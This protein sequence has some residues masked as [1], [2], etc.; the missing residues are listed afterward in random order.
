MTTKLD[1]HPPARE[2]TRLLGG[3]SDDRLDDP[4]PCKGTSVAALLDHLMGLTVA[5]RDAATKSNGP[6]SGQASAVA[7][8]LHPDWR[9]LLPQ[10]LDELAA[11][12]DDPA[13]W[14]GITWAGGVEMPAEVIASVAVDELVLHGWDLAKGTGQSFNCDLASAE[15]TFGFTSAM[16]EPGQEASR[17]GLF[18]PVVDVPVDAPLL[19][20]ALGFSGRDPGWSPPG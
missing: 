4:T 17:E 14:E 13:A 1:L 7:E 6:D 2:V 12:W 3:I 5:F 18:G 16:S 8:H 20:R 9:E 15:A 10:R 19:D 11:S